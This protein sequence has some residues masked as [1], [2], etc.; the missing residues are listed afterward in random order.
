MIDE[1]KEITY[2]VA[3]EK[4]DNMIVKTGPKLHHHLLL[5]VCLFI[6]PP[7]ALYLMWKYKEYHVWYATVSWVSG[8][9]LFVYTL[10][11]NFVILPNVQ[12]TLNSNGKGS[13]VTLGMS[14]ILILI[15]FALV[16]TGLGFYLRRQYK[17]RGDLTKGEMVLAIGLYGLG[18][19]LPGLIYG[20][21]VGPIYSSINLGI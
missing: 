8:A 9:L 16:Q 12:K 6:F 3:A 15:A 10:A 18:Y 2:Q 17:T 14:V 13:G 19:L 5:V 11:L 1:Q 7:V 21:I 20:N 4:L